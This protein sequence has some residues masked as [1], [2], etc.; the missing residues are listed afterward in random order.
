MKDENSTNEVVDAITAMQQRIAS[1]QAARGYVKGVVEQVDTDAN[2]AY[3]RV[4][5][6]DTTELVP[7][8]PI[9]G[10]LPKVGEPVLMN[11]NGVDPSVLAPTLMVEGDMQS[12]F[13]QEGVS[14]WMIDAAGNTEFNNATIRGILK[15]G[16]GSSYIRIAYDEGTDTHSIVFEEPID[17]GAPAYIQRIDDAT[18]RTLVIGGANSPS[19]PRI[20][21][22]SEI[23]APYRYRTN[24]YGLTAHHPDG[25]SDGYYSPFPTHLVAERTATITIANNAWH[26]GVPGIASIT[27]GVNRYQPAGGADTSPVGIAGGSLFTVY[28]EG[29]YKV[30]VNHQWAINGNGSRGIRLSGGS[31]AT[32]FIG[33]ETSGGALSS[34]SNHFTSARWI[35]I[36]AN[37]TF[38]LQVYQ[39]SGANLGL[40]YIQIGL[41]LVAL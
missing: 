22:L 20:E 19:A 38:Y 27:G 9:H 8:L 13:Y 24:F 29:T 37:E 4:G 6:D 32:K 40:T 31:M 26:S 28:A 30:T 15:T 25:G 21:L 14:G 7:L 17:S 23:G 11:L 34:G 2:V 16:F 35:R 1:A 10:F 3:V 12:R 33:E 5:N 39:N 36:A 41:E 18:W